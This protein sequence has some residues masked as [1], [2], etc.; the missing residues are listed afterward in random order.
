VG[1]KCGSGSITGAA[2]VCCLTVAAVFP[3]AARAQRWFAEASVQAQATATSNSGFESSGQKESDVIAEVTPSVVFRREGARLRLAGALALD[4]F[5]YVRGTQDSEIAPTGSLTANAVA[6][7]RLMF[8][9]AD[10]Q[11]TRTFTSPFG[12]RPDGASSVN[13][14]STTSARI[15]PYLDWQISP[16]LHATARN[17]SLWTRTTDADAD[18]SL[19]NAY[20]TRQT[21]ELAYLPRPVGL[22]I[23]Y[24]RNDS[25]FNGG[26]T[27]RYTTE[28]LRAIASL[29]IDP[30]LELQLRG[31]HESNNFPGYNTESGFYGGGI[32][33][34]PNER[35]SLSAY[36]EDRFFGTGWQLA[37]N[38]RMPRI[39][40]SVQ[41]SRD[42][43]TY[44]E[45]LL[46]LPAQ[47]SVSSL[48]DQT[49]MTR[50]PDPIERTRAVQDLIASRG[51][52]P[53][54]IV[55]V[56]FYTEQVSLMTSHSVNVLLLGARNSVGLSGFYLRTE[57]VVGGR[58]TLLLPT[59]LTNNAQVGGSVSFNHQ[60]S[61]VSGLS[62][63]ANWTRT[64]GL[65]DF[66]SF[67]TRQSGIR[68]QL[69]RLIGPRSSGF[70][71]LRYQDI[72]S[73][74]TNDA[75]EVAAIA[76]VSHRF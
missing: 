44:P 63:T 1:L 33:W 61:P 73:N 12:P 32:N 68:L 42:V 11:M 67:E 21:A 18:A 38:H 6:I 28:F 20:A 9:D 41:S 71:A 66:D 75:Q 59:E 69:N 17:E 57:T 31:G 60:L 23:S 72:N 58:D 64:R 29:A 48:L 10:V 45:L 51:L 74:V 53:F 47:I 36:A 2:A 49:L 5:T 50:I 46:T 16:R 62:M 19:R 35:T 7:E 54:V 4:A 76:G 14:Q 55:P 40:W 70:V 37:F 22:S 25:D 52:P 34:R 26:N 43:S 39:A 13:T 3:V 65:G 30:Q 24:Q 8:V 56:Q 15:S 27:D